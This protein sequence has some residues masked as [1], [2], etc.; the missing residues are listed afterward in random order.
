MWIK[1]M[2]EKS[3]RKIT[4]IISIII[5]ILIAVPLFFVSGFLE[6]DG[7]HN[8]MPAIEITHPYNNDVVSKIVTIYG[9]ASDPNGDVTIKN[10]EIMINGE[11]ELVDGTSTWKYNWDTYDLEDD[12]YHIKVRAWDGDKHSEIDEISIRVYNPE[13]VESDAHNWAVF[14]AAANFPKDN[15]SKLGNGGLVLAEEMAAYFIENLNYPTSNVV[16]LFDDGWIRS[17]NGFGEIVETLNKREHKYDIT[18]AG[19]TKENVVSILE[20][21]IK[22]ANQFDDSEVFVWIASHGLGDSNNPLFGGKLLQSSAVFLWDDI[23]TDEELGVIMSGLNSKKSCVIVDAC[24][25]GGFADKTILNFPTLFLLKS[26]LPGT[27]RVIMTGASKFRVG[28]ASVERG[29]L[30]SLLW[31][32]GIKSGNAD[33]FR[34]GLLKQGRPTKLKI[35]KD[36]KVSV[37]EAFYYARYVLDNDDELKDYNEME[38]QINDQYPGKGIILSSKGLVLG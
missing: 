7:K 12:I 26:N 23:L 3:N 1:R 8:R 35:F 20:N 11:W 22:E 38:P 16:I 17:D 13:I 14:I 18:Y 34:P 10:V 30:F 25:S 33:G 15:E 9:T 5:V 37:E 31:F 24:F 27:G 29:P 21:M 6:G 32:E 2:A 28:Y 19:A 36:G 4:V